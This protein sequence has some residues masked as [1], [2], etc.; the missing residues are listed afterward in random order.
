LIHKSGRTRR[1][2]VSITEGLVDAGIALYLSLLVIILLT[3]GFSLSF[4]GIT[5][6]GSH[7]FTPLKIL[8]PLILLRLAMTL[9]IKDFGLL[10]LSLVL[11][12]FCAEL[13]VRI[14]NPAV[15]KP[16]MAQIHRPSSQLGWELAPGSFGIGWSGESYRIN[17]DGFRDTEHH[18]T[19][20]PGTT[21]IMVI[22]DSFTFGPSVNLE[23]TYPK[24]LERILRQA[25][26]SCEVIN[27]GVIGYN[28]WQ[29]L[30]MLKGRVLSYEPDLLILGLFL[31]DINRSVPPSEGS[32]D[33]RGRNPF[34]PER[35]GLSGIMSRSALWNLLNYLNERFEARYRYRRGYGYL[36][37]IEER[38][39]HH[40]ITDPKR[41]WHKI[42]Y[43]KLEEQKY[44]EF[45]KAFKA[46]VQISEAS[47]AGV[48]AVMIP[49]AAQLHEPDRQ[50]INRF[51][52]QVCLETDVPFIDLTPAFE[53]EEDPRTLYMFPIDAHTSPRG[54]HLIAKSIAGGI[55]MFFPEI[56]FHGNVP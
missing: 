24:Q 29:Y 36:Q 49:D 11:S 28:M 35:R 26:V 32:A 5:V 33:W 56:F 18:K 6:K 20:T 46:F 50:A 43:G 55:E 30:E 8:I 3:G 9:K 13:V 12:L 22:G 23:E 15:S 21:R 19:K 47:G 27:C 48:L 31:N 54:H 16:Q 14:W 53:A 2:A 51:V 52:R 34:E 37:G 7:L 1:R 44:A 25:D 39:A 38:K 42:M 4:W 45:K 40:S 17:A 10:I 41:L